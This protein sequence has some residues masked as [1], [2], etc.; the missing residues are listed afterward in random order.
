MF[1]ASFWKKALFA[2][3][4]FNMFPAL[5]KSAMHRQDAA[6]QPLALEARIMFH[7][8]ILLCSLAGRGGAGA[9]PKI[10]APVNPPAHPRGGA[11]ADP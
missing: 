4:I 8:A 2:L 10:P 3:F 1:S 11:P 6:V 7:Q 5:D 9:H